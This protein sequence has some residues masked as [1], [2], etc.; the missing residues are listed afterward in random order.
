MATFVCSECNKVHNMS[1][2]TLIHKIPMHCFKIPENERA[3][4]IKVNDDLCSIDGKLYFIRGVLEMP[5]IGT[6]E[7]FDW[8][9]WALLEKKDF[10]KYIELWNAKI[11]KNMK[12]FEGFLEGAPRFY[13]DSNMVDITIQLRSKSKRPL[14]KIVSEQDEMGLDQRNGITM[15]KIH[16]FIDYVKSKR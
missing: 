1:E 7:T 10:D 12:S 16:S 14:F 15:E 5:I 3:K 8:G 4:R 6:K 9:L 13:P 11:A 2:M